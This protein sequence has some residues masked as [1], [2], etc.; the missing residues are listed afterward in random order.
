VAA[1]AAV[2]VEQVV[3]MGD[4]RVD[5]AYITFSFSKNL[6]AGNGPVYSHGLRVE[7]YSNFL[8][9]VLVAFGFLVAPN[10]DGYVAARILS[11]GLLAFGLYVVYRMARRAAGPLIALVAPASLIVCSDLVRATLSGLETTAYVVAIAFGWWVYLREP[12]WARRW[13]LLAFVPAA[14]MRIDGF[15]PV[16]IVCGVELLRSLSKRRLSHRALLRWAA[17]ALLIWS[18]YFAWRYWYYGLPLPTTYYAKQLVDVQQPNRGY[19]QVWA[20]LRDYGLLAIVPLMA[21]PLMALPLVR[22]RRTDALSLWTAIVLYFVFVGLT[23]GD[24][25]PFQRF[26]LPALP[27]G[28]VLLA[29][30]VARLQE[31]LRSQPLLARLMGGTL[32]L[33]GL[34]F[35]AVHVHM[36]SKDTDEE[37][38]KLAEAAHTKSHT[39]DNLMAAMNLA[40]WSIRNPGDRFAAEYAGVFAVFTDAY[41]ID[42]W[43][44]CNADIALHGGTEGINPVYAIYGKVCPRCFASLKPDYF[45]TTNPLVRKA[46]EFTSLDQVLNQ[47]FLGVDIDRYM[48]I[49]D[50]FAVGRVL[51]SATGRA[52]WFLERRRPHLPLVPRTPA[53][54]IRVDYPLEP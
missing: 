32:A 4:F 15:V 18:A 42:M 48:G 17:P 13:S 51:E 45:H 30:G 11:F 26:F 23:G 36:A 38:A 46:N 39:V 6:A 49:R 52:F 16:L 35:Y 2:G 44:L 27:L 33:G 1:I 5:D 43:G 25:M 9:M 29:W 47:V 28:A 19:D 40:R 53:P 21:L 24:W 7:G 54:G 34:A 31:E 50:N 12:P 22:R 14:L 8:W 3:R 20:L 10:S 37:R 41:V